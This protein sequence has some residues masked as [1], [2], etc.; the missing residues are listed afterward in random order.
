MVWLFVLGL[1]FWSFLQQLKITDLADRLSQLS[2]ELALLSGADAR[3]PTAE[4]AKSAEPLETPLVRAPTSIPATPEPTPSWPTSPSLAPTPPRPAPAPA[5]PPREPGPSVSDWLAENGLAWIG[6]G[7]LALGGLLLVAYAAQRG[8][9]TPALRIGAATALGLAALAAGEA[10]RRGV[11]AKTGPNLLVASLTTAA[12][13]ATLYAAIWAA[14]LLYHFIPAGEAGALLATVSLGLLALALLHGEA[15]GLL[16]IVAAYV[17]PVIS[18]DGGWGGNTLNGFVLL[19]LATGLGVAGL[20]GWSRAGAFAL[21]GAGLWAL[22]RLGGSDRTGAALITAAA[23]LLTLCAGVYANRSAR[24]SAAVGA[25]PFGRLL[26]AAV[27][28]ASVLT[29]LQWMTSSAAPPQEPLAATLAIILA[30]GLGVRAGLVAPT[31]LWAPAAALVYQP[32]WSSLVSHSHIAPWLMPALAALAIAG[33]DG[34]RRSRGARAAAVAGAAGAALTLTL[35]AAALAR[36]LPGLD[37]MVDAGFAV[38][39][40]TGA[41]ILARRSADA[42][43]DWAPAA[44]IAAAAETA[45]LALHASAD[46]RLAPTA[47]GLLALVLAALAVR[48]TWRGFAESAAVA[49]LASLASLLGAPVAGDALLGRMGPGAIL[50]VCGAA[51]MVQFAAWAVL[52]RRDDVRSSTE[53]IST[54]ALVSAL[55]GGFLALQ[56]LD[57][58]RAGASTLLDGFTEASLRTILLLAAGLV[59]AI[60]GAASPWG[61]ARAPVLLTLGVLHG[62]IMQGLLLHPWW[63]WTP[64]H[65]VLG[66][67]LADGLLLGL[68]APALLTADA[69]R[70]PGVRDARLSSA[71][72]AAALAFT[73]LWL[74]S[75]VRRLFH[76]PLLDQGPVSFSE[77]GAY[78]VAALGVA[79]LL[80]ASRAWLNALTASGRGI[81]E[82]VNAL[83]WVALALAFWLLTYVASPWWGPLEGD[84]DAPALLIAFYAAGCGLSAGLAWVARR[85]ARTLLARAALIAAGVEVFALISLI[86]RYAF[87]G[88]AMRAPLREAS[89]ETWTFSAIWALYGLLLLAVGAGRR[90]QALRG[91]GLAVLLGTTAKVFLFD[92]AR[93]DGPIRAASFLALGVVLLAGALAARRFAARTASQGPNEAAGNT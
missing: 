81:A 63:G 43:T 49:A 35:S 38:L 92:L 80:D 71:A 14:D 72:V 42:R 85:S 5:S 68:L 82:T 32:V 76:G 78:A 18:G 30:I 39:F 70:R 79:L 33:F 12:G 6:G 54:A 26:D 93:L 60:R 65:P 84:L 69:A 59:L 58:P 67:P 22:E 20:R 36:D 77:I 23:P 37:A 66:P 86:V 24:R 27:I 29:A 53:A 89:V 19:I 8:F 11:W 48:V 2:R 56:V 47:Y 13:A 41:T 4:T 50:V 1:A 55:L 3:A 17:V 9:F 87:H 45:G 31:L 34:A 75:E 15:L 52:R 83:A 61:R 7:A 40:A 91:L 10:L 64:G 25:D 57:Q 28:G 46:G 74:L 44:F 62:L 90:D 51:A 88:A 21:A 73:A 16:A